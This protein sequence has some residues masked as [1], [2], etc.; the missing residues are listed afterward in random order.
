[1]EKKLRNKN[2]EE[3]KAEILEME[4][5]NDNFLNGTTYSLWYYFTKLPK[6]I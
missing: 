2:K 5:Q 6:S 3:L 4:N 1:L